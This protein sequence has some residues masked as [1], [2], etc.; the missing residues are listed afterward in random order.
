MT[1]AIASTICEE[2][3]IIK[4]YECVTKSYPEFWND[5]I[6][7]GGALDEWNVGK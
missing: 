4:D 3:I 5:F 6:S 2:P 7:L 1:L